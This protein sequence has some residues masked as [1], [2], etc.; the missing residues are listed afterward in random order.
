[1]K[2]FTQHTMHCHVGV[3]GSCCLGNS[4]SWYPSLS[5]TVASICHHKNDKKFDSRPDHFETPTIT[6]K[7]VNIVLGNDLGAR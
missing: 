5:L 4:V 2:Q 3:S 6:L 1:M 7:S